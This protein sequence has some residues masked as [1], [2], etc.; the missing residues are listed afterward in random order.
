MHTNVC[1]Y[2]RIYI[3]VCVYMCVQVCVC[4]CV[5]VPLKKGHMPVLGLL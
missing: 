4:V 1:M 5:C 2:I 3:R